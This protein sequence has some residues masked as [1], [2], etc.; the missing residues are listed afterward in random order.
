M[1]IDF[2]SGQLSQSNCY[3]YMSVWMVQLQDREGRVCVP[4][5]P[6]FWCDDFVSCKLAVLLTLVPV[7][8]CACSLILPCLLFHLLLEYYVTRNY[9]FRQKC[10]GCFKYCALS[11]EIPFVSLACRSRL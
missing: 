3:F 5:G 2:I 4:S 1:L 11:A 8:H 6:W 7:L 9:N 10:W